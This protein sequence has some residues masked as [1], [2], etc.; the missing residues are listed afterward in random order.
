MY[1]RY[2]IADT[3]V[4]M[5]EEF[6]EHIFDE[7]SQEANNA[8]TQYRGTGLGMAITK[9]YVDLMGGTIRV[10][11]TKGVGSVF[12]VELPLEKTEADQ[13]HPVVVDVNAVSL[14]GIKVLLAED[15]DLNTEIARVQMEER[16]IQVTRAV[17]GM[18][19]VK[20]FASN[21]PGTFDLIFMDVMMPN[22]NGYEA[23]KE[24]RCMDRED[25]KTIPI[26]A[27]TA[28]AFAEDV[29]ASF[30]AGMNGHIA[31]PI[32][33]NEVEKAIIRNAN[34]TV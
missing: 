21:P 28:N 22:K 10:E 14:D 3:G 15:N 27:M 29:Q 17:D 6:L 9:R 2:R 24:I 8:R 26:I 19:A 5:S 25:A 12:T 20:Q 13:V 1:V 11:S 7:F 33:M 31:K 18:D 4:G 30:D 23:T 32:D 16:G 34:I